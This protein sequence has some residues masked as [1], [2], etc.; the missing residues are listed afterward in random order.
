MMTPF[1]IQMCV[2]DAMQ[3]DDIENIDSIRRM[4]NN[5]TELSWRAARGQEFT[6]DE[7]ETAIRDLLRTT[8][9]TPC[10]ESPQG[11]ECV[12]IAAERVDSDF[13]IESLWFHLEQSGRDAVNQWWESIGRVRFPLEQAD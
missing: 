1:D 13:P 12:P 6:V 7:V 9:I 3:D 4:L 2:A 10:A 8:M 11:G 5:A